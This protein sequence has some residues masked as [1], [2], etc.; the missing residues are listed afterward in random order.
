MFW[1]AVVW[2]LGVSCG[3]AIGMMAF[4]IMLTIWH[5]LSKT[6]LAKRID[7]LN[8]I[9]TELLKQRNVIGEDQSEVLTRMMMA[10]EELA[11]KQSE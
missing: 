1:T 3:A 9:N 4:V 7:E 2:G 8:E 6:K 10:M 5:W 11:K